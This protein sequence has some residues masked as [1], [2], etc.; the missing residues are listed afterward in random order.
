MKIRSLFINNQGT[1]WRGV[2]MALV[3]WICIGWN[4]YAQESMENTDE[5]FHTLDVEQ[6]LYLFIDELEE[7]NHRVSGLNKEQLHFADKS[8]LLI[9]KK[10]GVYTQAYQE[11]I[12]SNEHLMEIIGIYQENKQMV[13]DSIQIR[14]RKL[15]NVETFIKAEKFVFGQDNN[16]NEMF[17]LSQKYALLEKQAPLLEKLK[18]KEQLVF[19]ELT[20]YYE[21]AKSISQGEEALHGRMNKIE[22]QYIHLKSISEKI[23]AAEYKPFLERIKEYLYS[24]A[25]VAILLMFINMVTA[26]IQAYKQL[27]KSAEEYK[28]MIAGNEEEYPSI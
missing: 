16:Y 2:L 5:R 25:A 18:V 24:L 11:M 15:E 14:I 8:L 27:K 12:A 23:Q 10:W 22:D 7:L 13:S 26:K 4:V 21:S 6:R 9:D 17:E 20:Q 3:G 1:M 19:T 28:K